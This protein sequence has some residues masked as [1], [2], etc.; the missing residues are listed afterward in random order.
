MIRRYP[1]QIAI[2]F[3]LGIC[4]AKAVSQKEYLFAAAVFVSVFCSIG[5]WASREQVKWLKLRQ[6]VMLALVFMLG[7]ARMYMAA[8]GLE[9]R[10]NGLE[11]GAAA[12]VQG[13]IIKKQLKE[14]VQGAL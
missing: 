12:D 5:I 13:R 3:V 2:V 6:L 7:F 1:C 9:S 10:L 14:T 4:L 8:A 11:D